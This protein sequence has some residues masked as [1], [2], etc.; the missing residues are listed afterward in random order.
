MRAWIGLGLTAL[1]LAC[2]T[3]SVE[4]QYFG[5]PPP[6]PPVFL[7]PPGA[8]NQSFS[9]GLVQPLGAR[10]ST[11]FGICL[12]N[13]VGPLQSPCFCQSMNGPVGGAVVP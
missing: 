7:P 9:P 8:F 1:A 3:G 11:A 13:G 12:M 6:P 5:V 10:C 2:L 4:A